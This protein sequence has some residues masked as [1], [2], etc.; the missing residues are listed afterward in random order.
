MFADCFGQ[1]LSAV[2]QAELKAGGG[3]ST[4]G[5]SLNERPENAEN[6]FSHADDPRCR[7]SS[8]RVAGDGFE[9]AFR[10]AWRHWRAETR[11]PRSCRRAR[12]HIESCCVESK[13]RENTNR[14]N[15]R[16]K[17]G[18][19]ILCWPCPRMGE[20]RFIEQFRDAGGGERRGPATEARRID[21]SSRDR[22]TACS[23]SPLTMNLGRC[24]VSPRGSR[25]R[26]WS[27][28]QEAIR[29][30]IRSARTTS[31][32]LIAVRDIFWSSAT[33]TSLC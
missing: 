12:L 14:W 28:A 13:A 7:N 17:P 23:W 20:D 26:F 32:R 9:H 30:S 27:T 10:P 16:A 22:L 4:T 33:R 19:R 8:G 18:Q 21:R 15:R 6:T 5:S 25:Q 11:R 1:L 3:S 24:R 2:G 31:T 29:T